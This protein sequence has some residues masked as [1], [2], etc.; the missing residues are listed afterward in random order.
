MYRI[1]G[2]KGS[3]SNQHMPKVLHHQ[4]EGPSTKPNTRLLC[5][6]VSWGISL[7]FYVKVS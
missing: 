4:S 1:C 2:A 7:E 5:F 3:T 6:D